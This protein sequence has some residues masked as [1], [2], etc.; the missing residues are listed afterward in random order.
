MPRMQMDR[1]S[2]KLPFTTAHPP[3]WTCPTCQK[4]ILRIR[5]DTFFHEETRDSRDH[6]HY[7]WEP[8]W[9]QY[10]YTCLLTCQNHLCQEVVVNTG[11]G[12]VEAFYSE[13][14]HALNEAVE[15]YDDYFSPKFF[16]PHL[17]LMKIPKNCPD[18]VSEPLRESFRLFFA[19]PNAAANNVRIAIEELLTVLKIKRS[20]VSSKKKKN[21]RQ[22]LSL[23]SRISLLTGK[24]ESYKEMLF[25]I[26]WLGNAGSHGGNGTSSDDVI[27]SYEL[28][29]HIL[30]EIYA[31]KRKHLA[32][33]AKKVNKKRGPVS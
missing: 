10:V 13:Y 21:K 5:K 24:Y 18:S 6:S 2:L 29:E 19:S 32:S 16:E 8:S 33:L 3:E 15:D 27:D 12:S 1:K 28:T 22:P 7:A 20:T 26:K 30:Q 9:I 4:G 17:E 25:A 11:V 14:D 31:P 23:H